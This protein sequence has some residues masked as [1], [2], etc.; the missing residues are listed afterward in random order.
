MTLLPN[1]P[2]T[3]EKVILSPIEDADVGDH[4]VGW[5][6][7]PEVTRYLGAV[8]ASAPSLA[9]LKKY[10]ERFQHSASDMILAIRDRGTRAHIG[11]IT[12]NHIDWM[13]HTGHLGIMIG[14]KAFWGKGYAFEAQRL[15]LTYLFQEVKLRKV[16]AGAPINN[17][18]S[19]ITLK[20]L[21]FQTE[22]VLRQEAVVD[23][24]YRDVI[25]LGLLADEFRL[26]AMPAGAA[27]ATAVAA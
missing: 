5:L 27:S 9:S 15:F 19:I 18:A 13:T 11:N 20:K 10:L 1:A 24:A 26:G 6:S 25:R 23:G 3:G 22:G 12:I 8:R 2:L 16:T 4:Y 21:G 17:L 14:H 7:D